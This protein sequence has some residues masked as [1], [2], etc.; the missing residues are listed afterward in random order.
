MSRKEKGKKPKI[1]KYKHNSSFMLNSKLVSLS[2]V[3]G[4]NRKLEH[5]KSA[6]VIQTV[7][8]NLKNNENWRQHKSEKR[9]RI[10]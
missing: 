2:K 8:K 5:S 1:T 9:Y 3:L 4:I 7:S 6:T 10:T